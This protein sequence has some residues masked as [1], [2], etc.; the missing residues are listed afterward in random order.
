MGRKTGKFAEPKAGIRG[1][2]MG[3]RVLTGWGTCYT[4]VPANMPSWE[5]T[6]SLDSPGGSWSF[7]GSQAHWIVSNPSVLQRRQ[8]NAEA[9]IFVKQGIKETASQWDMHAN[10]PLGLWS[11][12]EQAA[13]LSN[14]LNLSSEIT[15]EQGLCESAVS[16]SNRVL[17]REEIRPSRNQYF[18]VF[19]RTPGVM[20]TGCS[21]PISRLLWKPQCYY[22]PQAAEHS[23]VWGSTE[24]MG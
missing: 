19:P 21:L 12:W 11:T 8:R 6:G 1:L 13:I 14:Y 5:R 15:T 10:S 9:E 23:K 20:T 4:P 3:A 18:P 16:V 2:E 24:F 7:R 17:R 22:L